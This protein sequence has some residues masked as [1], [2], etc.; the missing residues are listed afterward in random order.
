MV[1]DL[2]NL[3]QY[4]NYDIKKI[5]LENLVV[6]ISIQTYLKIYMYAF[7]FQTSISY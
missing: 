2:I 5:D 7:E 3:L 4:V 6:D 1:I